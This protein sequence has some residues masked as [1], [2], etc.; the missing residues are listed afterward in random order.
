MAEITSSKRRETLSLSAFAAKNRFAVRNLG[1][2]ELLSR[3]GENEDT[4][5]IVLNGT[6]Y[7]AEINESGKKNILEFFYTGDII[8]GNM[9]PD[10]HTGS[11]SCLFAHS[12][13]EVA[14]LSFS[15]LIKVAAKGDEAAKQLIRSAYTEIAG[16]IFIHTS[17]LQQR[18]IEDKLMTFFRFLSRK[19]SSNEF[20]IPVSYTDLADYLAADR[21][22]M[23]REIRRLNDTGKI[24]SDKFKITLLS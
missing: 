20:E 16:R 15:R 24:H 12:N 22:A 2:R 17:I 6:A 19:N 9:F 1:K 4:I 14:V 7:I 18:T 5:Y 23:M 10:I 13:C 8:S 11:Y 21:S 3:E